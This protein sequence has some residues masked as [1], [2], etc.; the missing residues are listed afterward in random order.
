[1]G[2]N[3]GFGIYILC[4]QKYTIPFLFQVENW[5]L[6]IISRNEVN[7]GVTHGHLVRITGSMLLKEY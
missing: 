2:L 3:A 4:G 6:I 5:P 1:M 7:A